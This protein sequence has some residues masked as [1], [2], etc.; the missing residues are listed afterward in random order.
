MARIDRLFA[1]A[2]YKVLEL[3][4]RPKHDVLVKL[5]GLSKQGAE[6]D[7][8]GQ[9]PEML[10]V[11]ARAKYDAWYGYMGMGKNN[12][13]QAYIDLVNKLLKN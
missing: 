13:K 8:S 6:G 4:D 1:K 10:E 2:Q 3:K 7:V 12:A 5:Y 11:N 9:R